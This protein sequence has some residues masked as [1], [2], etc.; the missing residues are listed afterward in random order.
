MHEFVG[1][2]ADG[3]SPCGALIAD[4]DRL[5]GMTSRGGRGK[6]GVMFRLKP[7][8]SDYTVLHVFQGWYYD[9]DTP[10]GTLLL[11]AGKFY[12]LTAR[13]GT[14][15][16][17]VLFRINKD[18]SDFALLRCFSGGRADGATPYGSLTADAAAFYGTTFAG[19]SRNKGVLFRVNK[20]GSDYKV[21]H[22]FTGGFDNGSNPAGSLLVHGDLLIGMTFDGG[23]GDK[24]IIFSIH[25]D[26]TGFRILRNFPSNGA[27][28]SH[29]HGSLALHN[30]TLYG[31]TR[32]GGRGE[33]GVLFSLKPD[34]K[35]FTVLRRFADPS[36][37]TTTD[38]GI[39]PY[40][41]LSVHENTLYGMTRRGGKGGGVL[42]RYALSTP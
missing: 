41:S 8:G 12:G 26:G 38:D 22:H 32:T 39:E 33:A 4:G 2:D 17:G 31:V 34:G 6:G 19:G 16:S 37:H 13:G 14:N 5:Y 20:D 27:E 42:F 36:S 18:G 29:P 7:D 9:G 1:G 40:G 11:D 3:H 25:K 24:G 21:L 35:Q 10:Y 15:D 28:G 30:E 23:S